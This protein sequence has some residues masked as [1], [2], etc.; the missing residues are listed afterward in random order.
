MDPRQVFC[1]NPACA[2]R[3]QSRQGNI[4]VHSQKDQR[5]RCHVCHKTVVARTASAF[6]RLHTDEAIVSQVVTLLAYGC[7]VQAIVA[8]FT[9]DERMVA[10][11]QKRAGQHC[12]RLHAHLVEQPRDLGQVQADEIRV[13][14]ARRC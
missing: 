14:V 3:S 7:P 1:P 12:E 2:A 6:Y 11:W 4:S 13:K 5:Y 10:D 8:A 9:L